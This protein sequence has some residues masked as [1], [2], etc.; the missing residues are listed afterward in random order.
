MK[1]TERSSKKTSKQTKKEAAVR[2]SVATASQ[3]EDAN[4]E[5]QTFWQNIG[6]A[7]KT[8][9]GGINVR[10]NA[11]PVNGQLY[12]NLK[13]KVRDEDDEDFDFED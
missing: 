4:G 10:L 9:N 13:P 6:S 3:Y 8:K 12:I 2:L 7:F 5:E 11:L 1:Q